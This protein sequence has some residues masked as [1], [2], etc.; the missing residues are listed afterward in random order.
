M[1]VGIG[2]TMRQRMRQEPNE[3]PVRLRSPAEQRRLRNLKL[4]T[5]PDGG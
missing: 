4:K 5:E 3:P 2:I 1:E